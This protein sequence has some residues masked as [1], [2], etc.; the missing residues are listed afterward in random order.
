MCEYCK[1]PCG[2]HHPSCPKAQDPPVMGYCIQCNQELRQDYEYY[3]DNEDNKF[4]SEE[5]A[6]QY[7]GIKE[8]EWDDD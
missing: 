5:C 1:L 8:M 2:L 7:H 3:I 6:I 4:C